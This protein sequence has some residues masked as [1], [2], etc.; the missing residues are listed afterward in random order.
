MPTRVIYVG[1]AEDKAVRL[2]DRVETTTGAAY[3]VLSHCWGEGPQQIMLTSSTVDMFKEGISWSS[4]PKTFQDAILVTRRF[5][6]QYIWIDS[7]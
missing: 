7:L 5:E 6:I 3:S 4:L 2:C 1:S